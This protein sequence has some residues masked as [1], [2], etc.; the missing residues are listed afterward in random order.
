M[1]LEQTSTLRLR[2]VIFFT[3]DAYYM[4]KPGFKAGPQSMNRRLAQKAERNSFP[5]RKSY[6]WKSMGV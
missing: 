4:K 1:T 2:E 5:G 6:V 3:Q